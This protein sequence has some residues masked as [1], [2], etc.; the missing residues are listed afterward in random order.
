MN[1]FFQAILVVFV[2][3]GLVGCAG[4]PFRQR[5]LYGPTAGNQCSETLEAPTT[6]GILF[7]APGFDLQKVDEARGQYLTSKPQ[8]IESIE[9]PC[10]FERCP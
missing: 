2:V 4:S 7:G 8:P 1:K 10:G 3:F 9:L 5:M 6:L